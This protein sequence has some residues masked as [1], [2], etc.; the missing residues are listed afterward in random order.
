MNFSAILTLPVV[1][2]VLSAFACWVFIRLTGSFFVAKPREWTPD[3]HHQTKQGIPTMGGL[4]LVWLW[5][6]GVLSPYTPESWWNTSL[7]LLIVL[8]MGFLGV[9][10]DWSKI[11]RKGGISARTKFI[12]QNLSA[13]IVM[14]AWYWINPV[15]AG[16][17]W[18]PFFNVS[19]FLGPIAIIWGTFIITAMSNAINLTD[20]LDGLAGTVLSISFFCIAACA[21]LLEQMDILFGALIAAG[22]FLGFLCFNLHPARLFMGDTGAL[23]FGALLGFY[24]VQLNL[25]LL[26][27]V[28]AIIPLLETVSVMLQVAWYKLYKIRI[29]KMAP[30][31]HHFEI[32]GYTENQIVATAG[33]FTLGGCVF[34]LVVVCFKI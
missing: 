18:I 33:L 23:A 4:V 19:L 1:L 28:I 6:M 27:P 13:V 5:I 20:G 22:I 24:A 7:G 8:S 16:S 26:L 12:M 11:T 17:V 32:S 9:Y 10:D 2:F 30:I 29:F 15:F 34:A 3:R 31:H 21:G 25:T 14:I